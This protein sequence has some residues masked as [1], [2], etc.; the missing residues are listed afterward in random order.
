MQNEFKTFIK[1]FIGTN[2]NRSVKNFDYL[3]SR[4]RYF[5]EVTQT[6]LYN[7]GKFKKA[8]QKSVTKLTRL[9]K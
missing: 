2:T 9:K 1:N 6:N 5:L 4:V 8:L 3:V 7:K